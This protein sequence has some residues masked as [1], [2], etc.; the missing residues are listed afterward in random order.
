MSRL[1]DLTPE[2]TA[3]HVSAWL[4]ASV[5][6]CAC[7]DRQTVM[8]IKT[9]KTSDTLWYIGE[10]LS[11]IKTLRWC[12]RF[13]DTRPHVKHALVRKRTAVLHPW[14]HFR[15]RFFNHYFSPSS[16]LTFSASKIDL[17][18]RWIGKSLQIQPIPCPF[19]APSWDVTMERTSR[20]LW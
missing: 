4:H 20:L 10:K 6:L 2:F 8:M 12:A 16:T 19:I 3:D 14:S 1:S 7:V 15:F 17:C 9:Q 18:Y 5:W 13:T 11:N